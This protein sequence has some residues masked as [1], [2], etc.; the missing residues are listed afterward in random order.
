MVLSK[1]IALRTLLAGLT[2]ILVIEFLRIFNDSHLDSFWR[3]YNANLIEPLEIVSLFLFFLGLFLLFFN[4]TIQLL[5]WR[6][7]R[8]VMVASIPV[9]LTGSSTGYVW[10]RRTDLVVLCG[11][12]LLGATVLFALYQRWYRKTGV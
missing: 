1:K 2:L 7:A 9:I 6:W 8:W 11:S 4:Q 3:Q 10:F 5:W 12:T